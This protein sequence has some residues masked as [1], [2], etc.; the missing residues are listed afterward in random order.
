MIPISLC[1][2]TKNEGIKLEKCLSRIK[3]YP[4]EIIVVDT[5][6]TDKTVAIAQKYTDKIF[7]F[8]WINDFAAAR[9]FS[10][11][12]AS[13]DWILVLDSDEYVEDMNLE[14]IYRLIKENPGGVGRLLRHSDDIA[15][16]TT[17]DRV[18][19]LFNRQ[20][21]HYKRPIHEQVLP[22]D[23]ATPYFDFPIPLTV[24]HE[25]YIGTFEDISRKARRNLAILLD[26]E[27]DFPDSYTYFQIGQ[28]YYIMQQ[29]EKARE[30]YEKG[31]SFDLSPTSEFVQLMIISYGYTLLHLGEK[32]TAR[33]FFELIEEPF[34]FYADFQ[35]FMGY[36]YLKCESYMKSVL[37]FIKAT[38]RSH[39]HTQGT[40]SYLAYYHLGILYEMMGNLDLARSFYKK[41]EDY[42]PS[43]ERL[44]KLDSLNPNCI[45]STTEVN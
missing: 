35:F 8:D 5:G 41:S 34:D 19:R 2:I 1:I 14:E 4:L 10:I 17:V 16:N 33:E 13:H 31:L 39:F 44:D 42:T 6:S 30:Y 22:I 43:R 7:H 11:S 9:N 20:I 29:W 28:S 23:P 38:Q 27:K 45:L 3:D 12:K 18:E 36:L 32:D 40:N 37:Y 24:E 26:S 25:G 21:Y 15:N